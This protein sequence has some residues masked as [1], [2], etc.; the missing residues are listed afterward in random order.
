M[1][2]YYDDRSINSS[3]TRESSEGMSAS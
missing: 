1:G 2:M 3:L